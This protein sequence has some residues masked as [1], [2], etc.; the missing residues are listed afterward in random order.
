MA[1]Y[2]NPLLLKQADPFIYKH[3]DGFYYFNAS[4]PEFDRIDLR[5]AKTIDGLREAQAITI[6]AKS[7]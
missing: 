4:A 5:R 1:P 2:H 7:K 6:W 3:T